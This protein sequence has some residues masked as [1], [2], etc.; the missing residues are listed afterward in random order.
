MKKS[1][2]ALAVL[3][4]FA[5]AASAQSS[6]TLYGTM[7]LGLV[8]QTGTDWRLDSGN[9]ISQLGF[10]G[11]ED[12]G[13]GMAGIFDLRTRLSPES[14]GQD[15]SNNKRPFWQSISAVGLQGGF[16]KV[17]VGRML[18]AFQ[19]PVNST[20]PWGTEQQG[21]PFLP[22]GYSSEPAG[23]LNQDGA[24]LG[25]ADVITYTTPSLGGFGVAVS[26][27]P[28]RSNDTGTGIT[29]PN[30]LFGLWASYAAGPLY[31]GGGTEKN[32]DGDKIAM[33]LGSYDFGVVKVMGG[34]AQVDAL[35]NHASLVPASVTVSSAGVVTGVAQATDTL[36]AGKKGQN[37]NFGLVAPFGPF[38]AKFGYGRRKAETATTAAYQ[39]E[40]NKVAVGADYI[41]SK[42]TNLYTSY[43]QQ[44]VKTSATATTTTKGLDFGIKHNF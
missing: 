10:R 32:R 35:S 9:G 26:V 5:G 43:G 27:G 39:Q 3:G 6:V 17:L 12:L 8:R 40:T 44:R 1:L 31:I 13:G 11:V 23:T 34:V 29:H 41:L 20:D 15:G 24:G 42:R 2:L 25:R 21:V 36:L 4:A 37:M 22:A 38:V 28:K 7:D 30:A 19:A 33:L 14:G 18:T 16:G